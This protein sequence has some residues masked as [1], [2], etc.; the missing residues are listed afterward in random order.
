MSCRSNSKRAYAGMIASVFQ[1]TANSLF[2]LARKTGRTYNEINVLIYYGLIPLSYCVLLDL[3][4]GVHYL[5]LA[6]LSFCVGIVIG[7]PDFKSFSDRLF[8]RSVQFLNYFNR[9]G[10][11]YELSSVL[12]CLLLPLTIYAILIRMVWIN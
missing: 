11:N 6:F 10:S 12:I 3:L 9:F 5:K 1:L 8:K 7:T 2:W 4:W